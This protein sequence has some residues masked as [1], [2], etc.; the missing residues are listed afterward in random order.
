MEPEPK[1]P[2]SI[3]ISN[4]LTFF[5]Y[6]DSGRRWGW[7]SLIN[8]SLNFF[9]CHD[10]WANF[11]KE[12]FPPSSSVYRSKT[13][14]WMK[15][16]SMHPRNPRS[17]LSTPPLESLAFSRALIFSSMILLWLWWEIPV[18]T[19][20]SSQQLGWM[21]CHICQLLNSTQL[22]LWAWKSTS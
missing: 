1:V 10:I 16:N 11:F 18:W 12:I 7:H 19:P 21:F 3:V 2:I 9:R 4:S 6:G 17:W 13:F 20:Y 15:I 5:P 22:G 14:S 8:V